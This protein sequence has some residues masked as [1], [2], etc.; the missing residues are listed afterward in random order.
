[1]VDDGTM[2]LQI[3]THFLK[4]EPGSSSEACPKSSHDGIQ[5]SDVKVEE[6]PVPITFPGMKAEH[7][8]SCMSVC[9][10]LGTFHKYPE[11]CTV[12]LISICLSVNMNISGLLKGRF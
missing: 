6:D 7:E 3:C 5:I 11:L 8:V 9:P 10:L 1:V 4:I 2:V 12:F